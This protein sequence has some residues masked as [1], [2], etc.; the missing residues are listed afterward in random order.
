MFYS[1]F[2]L[3]NFAYIMVNGKPYA[4]YLRYINRNAWNAVDRFFPPYEHTDFAFTKVGSFAINESG[5]GKTDF[6]LALHCCFRGKDPQVR[7]QDPVLHCT[8]CRCVYR[9]TGAFL[10]RLRGCNFPPDLFC[11][12]QTNHAKFYFSNLFLSRF[13][14]KTEFI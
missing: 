12:N 9:I 1:I 2:K 8:F 14:N 6:P 5:V 3:S 11:S 7:W 10:V 13:Q 4:Y